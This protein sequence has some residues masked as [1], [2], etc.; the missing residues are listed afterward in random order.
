VSW[1]LNEMNIPDNQRHRGKILLITGV[2]IAFFLAI[3]T[4]T[5]LYQLKQA[6]FFNTESIFPLYLLLINSFLLNT[7]YLIFFERTQRLWQP[8]AFLFGFDAIFI[9]ALILIT[10]TQ[11]SIFLFM[12]LVNI[13]L[14]GFVFQK[15]G[16]L[17]LALF[18]SACFSFLLIFGPEVQGQTLYYAVGLNNLAFFSVAGLSG[19]LSEQL[20]FIGKELNI[21]TRDIKV[22]TDLNKIIV[23]NI[24]SGIITTSIDYHIILA[25]KSAEKILSR[26]NLTLLNVKDIFPGL[27]LQERR[28]ERKHIL[29]NGERII[30]GLSLSPLMNDENAVNGYILIFQDLTEV[31]R[32]ESSMRRQEKLAA[33]GKLAAGIAHEIR[34]P[35]ASI[36]G[37]IQLL[38]TMLSLTTPDQIKLMDIMVKETDRLN[39][40]ITEFLDFVRPEERKLE[41]CDIDRILND[42]LDVVQ[43]NANLPK[44]VLQIRLLNSQ[45]F[46][47]GDKNKLKQVF[48]NF[49][50]NAYQ[51]MSE[52]E[53]GSLT[54]QTLNEH[55]G[56]VVKISDTGSGMSEITMKR[57]FE[58]FF[59]TKAKGT[60][61]GLATA[62]KILE[63]H[64]AK[65][66]V[67]SHEDKGTDFTIRFNEVIKQGAIH[68]EGQNT[69]S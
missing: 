2:R 8:T 66:F 37:S 55:G 62:H 14:C 25:N 13:I 36:S 17:L 48:L 34:N 12:Y 11:T 29:P 50:I 23:E 58:P 18:T 44:H 65:I 53:K 6:T 67:E 64:D 49:M 51:S 24:S 60:G 7:I 21:K 38:R 41:V 5:V 35:L 43:L 10:G 27:S 45:S 15:K 30:L 57:L 56:V 68:H 33:V 16:A 52:K 9:T 32:L 61:L 19:Y 3:L 28:T 40:L 39:S 47:A 26:T 69:G 42:V 20:N 59:T 22:L 63:T 46:V 54:V 31:V 4:I 1:K